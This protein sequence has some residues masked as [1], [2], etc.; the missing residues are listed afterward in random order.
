MVV[1]P[2]PGMAGT[3]RFFSVSGRAFCLYAVIGS[4]SRRPVLVS[5]LNDALSTL[6]ISPR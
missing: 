6:R 4:A 1:G 2:I 5:R 3:Q